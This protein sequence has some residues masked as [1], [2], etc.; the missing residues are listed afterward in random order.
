M[1]KRTGKYYGGGRK[2][3]F[4][5]G[6][7]THTVRAPLGVTT[8]DVV[9]LLKA[10]ETIKF[11]CELASRHTSPR[12]EKLKQLCEELELKKEAGG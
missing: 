12:W 2:S 11:W 4:G 3:P 10:R 5:P 1:A 8:D 6:V 9:R 7:K